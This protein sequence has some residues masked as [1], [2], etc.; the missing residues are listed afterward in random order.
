MKMKKLPA[1]ILC[2][3]LS[4]SAMAELRL[5]LIPLDQASKS[6]ADLALAEL[7]NDDGLAFLERTEIAAIE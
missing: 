1:V 2:C 7:S 4:L 5:A 6:M 3:L